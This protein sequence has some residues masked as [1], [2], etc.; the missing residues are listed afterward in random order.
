MRT[1]KGK[2]RAHKILDPENGTIERIIAAALDRRGTEI[3][4]LR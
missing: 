4:D 3:A 2:S 1:G